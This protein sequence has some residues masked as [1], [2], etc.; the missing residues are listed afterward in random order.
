MDRRYTCVRHGSTCATSPSFCR[1]PSPP[2]ACFLSLI[3]F[4]ICRQSARAQ[5]VLPLRRAPS[6]PP[7][8]LFVCWLCFLLSR[9]SPWTIFQLSTLPSFSPPPLLPPSPS[10]SPALLPPLA[11]RPVARPVP[12]LPVP[13]PLFQ[14]HPLPPIPLSLSLSSPTP[15][16]LG[17]WVTERRGGS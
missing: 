17:V 10:P 1:L 14:F 8:G 2:V 6:L 7:A 16:S 5:G 9:S 13:A 4:S 12:S 15:L 3:S 11:L